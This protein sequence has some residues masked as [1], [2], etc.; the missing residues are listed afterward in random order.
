MNAASTIPTE[1]SQD[2]AAGNVK[3][4]MKDAG[5]GSGDL[6]KVPVNKL[7][8]LPGFNV[9]TKTPEYEAHIE[10]LT[11]SILANGFYANQPL[12]VII[13]ESGQVIVH[14]G[15]SRLE[16]AKRAIA[17]G[18]QIETLPVVTSPRGTTM[19]DLTIGLVTNNT[20]KPLSPIEVAVVIKRMVGWGRDTKDIAS[21]LGV[22]EGYVNDLLGLL[23]APEAT[24]QLVAAGKVAAGTAIKLG[25]K[26]GAKEAAKQL[27]AAAAALPAGKTV[28]PKHL[29]ESA[30]TESEQPAAKTYLSPAATKIPVT[31]AQLRA[32]L[33]MVFDDKNFAKLADKVQSKVIDI[34]G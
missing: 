26:V 19:E 30:K 20:G 18:A 21:K 11:Q 8:V 29:K 23:E 28:T 2:F 25:K 5:A 12:G 33:K 7:V 32:A 1:F 6:Y 27:Q 31:E 17:L 13:D 24:K 15:H 3:A 4:A 22:T 16:A 9:R 14:S 34:V 10:Q